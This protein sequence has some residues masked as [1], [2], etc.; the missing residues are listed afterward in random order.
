M[1]KHVAG[2]LVGNDVRVIGEDVVEDGA[3]IFPWNTKRVRRKQSS[4]VA[5]QKEAAAPP[6]TSPTSPT[7]SSSIRFNLLVSIPQNLPFNTIKSNFLLQVA[8]TR[9]RAL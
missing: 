8:L 2:H 4:R 5:L 9:S 3:V 7:S 6:V 1:R